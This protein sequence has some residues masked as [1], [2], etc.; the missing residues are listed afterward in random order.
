MIK[1]L[2]TGVIISILLISGCGL[3]SQ[4]SD[5]MNTSLSSAKQKATFA[6]M[7]ENCP[8]ENLDKESIEILS[9]NF[10]KDKNHV[11][12]SGRIDCI[13]ELKGAD[14]KTFTA[15]ND[16]FGKD[17]NSVYR[18]SY[19]VEGADVT[20]FEIV[21]STDFKEGTCA[22]DKN[23]YYSSDYIGERDVYG[24]KISDS[25]KKENTEINN[26]KVVTWCDKRMM[27]E[28]KETFHQGNLW[29]SS[30]E[31]SGINH[32]PTVQHFCHEDTELFTLEME[33]S[34]DASV[35]KGKLISKN[36]N[37]TFLVNSK[38]KDPKVELLN[39]RNGKNN[40]EVWFTL[41]GK[42]FLFDLTTNKFIENPKR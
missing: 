36:S 34:N 7:F 30:E 15:L 37:G 3:S 39:E 27:E 33:W 38:N 23:R 1:Y 22:K 35:Y 13:I 2:K 29:I 5:V 16:E 31:F 14:P 17:K 8:L 28:L 41:D 19:K 24:D 25:C 4:N 6:Q 26:D 32:A 21:T 18:R 42:I 9:G 40:N 10:A 11:Y 20:T 12:V